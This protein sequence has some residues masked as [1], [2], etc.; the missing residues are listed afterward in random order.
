M[1]TRDLGTGSLLSTFSVGRTGGGGGGSGGGGGGE[2][3]MTRLRLAPRSLRGPLG[4]P[5]SSPLTATHF[6]YPFSSPSSRVFFFLLYFSLIFPLYLSA[7]P[8][9]FIILLY[10]E[11][12]KFYLCLSSLSE[13]LLSYL[14]RQKAKGV[15]KRHLLIHSQMLGVIKDMYF[16]PL[17]NINFCVEIVKVDLT[18]AKC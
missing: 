15:K 4:P 9:F 5:Q 12:P 3:G 13:W 11:D 1:S 16:H 10:Q 18:R 2:Q 7:C 6:F 8:V 17:I 14:T